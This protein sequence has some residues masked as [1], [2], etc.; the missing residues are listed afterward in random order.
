MSSSMSNLEGQ[1]LGRYHILE[2]LGEGGMATVYKAYDTRLETDV[3]IKVI[4]TENLAPNVLER[5]R[6]RFEREAKSLARL[7]HPNIVQV[8]DFGEYHSIPYLV[9]PYIPGG[10]LKE[11]IKRGHIPWGETVR[12]LVPIARALEYAHHQKIVH[13]DIKPSNVLIT[14]SG[15]PMLSDF[16]VAKVLDVDETAELT[17]TGMGVGTPEYMAPEQFQGRTDARA[18]IYALG[19]VMYE[20]L[21]GRKPYIAKTPAAV[22][23][24]QATEPLPRPNR[25]AP[26]LPASIEKIL[27]KSLAKSPN[28]R[29]QN[30]GDFAQALEDVILAQERE[31]QQQEEIRKKEE[32]QQQKREEQKKQRDLQQ[33]QKLEAQK[34]KNEQKKQNREL[35][36]LQHLEARKQRVPGKRLPVNIM[37]GGMVGLLFLSAIGWLS[38]SGALGSTKAG[39]DTDDDR[40]KEQSLTPFYLPSVTGTTPL[41]INTPTLTATS[42]TLSSVNTPTMA[43]LPPSTLHPS[44]IEI[45]DS[46]GV[47]MVLIPTGKF[48]MGSDEDENAKPVHTVYLDTFYMDKYEVTNALYESCVSAYGCVQPTREGDGY[49]GEGFVIRPYTGRQSYYGNV[50]YD[51]YP[52]M[53]VTWKMADIFCQWRGARLPTEAEWEKAARGK[54]GLTYSDWSRSNYSRNQIYSTSEVGLYETDKS[55]YGIYDMFG[56][57]DEFVADWYQEDYYQTLGDFVSNPTGPLSGDGH[58]VR[59][60]YATLRYMISTFSSE[61]TLGFRCARDTEPQE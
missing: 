30:M 9:M 21:T 47:P 6:K 56:N 49:E 55:P 38:F 45:T 28:D 22:I 18:D 14:E 26:D 5:V 36:K 25:L 2:Q 53:Y 42:T 34:R 11:H 1:S 16:G 10:T 12:S 58:V 4:R 29:Y 46:K 24:K 19:V 43:L 13:R 40:T 57:V 31:N 27:I 23:I 59:G 52:V 48:I 32:L 35:Q 60:G 8:I 7:N 37:L 61:D 39:F 33:K 44:F 41:P 50:K 3:A 20:M 17:G 15:A 54:D 51:N